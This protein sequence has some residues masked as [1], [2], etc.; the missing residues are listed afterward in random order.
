MVTPDP[1][2]VLGA[3]VQ[4]PSDRLGPVRYANFDIAA[5]APCLAVAAD[6]VNA[7]L[8]WYASV[9]RGAGALSQR[10]TIIEPC[11]YK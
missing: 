3:D 8:P 4:V 7:L 5:S 2:A 10:C 6:A 11:I 1:L 9:H